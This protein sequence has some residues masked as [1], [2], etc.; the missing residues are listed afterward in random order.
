MKLTCETVITVYTTGTCLEIYNKAV[1]ISCRGVTTGDVEWSI[2]KR[3]LGR[4]PIHG[5]SAVATIVLHTFWSD[6]RSGC[7]LAIK[8]STCTLSTCTLT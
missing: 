3:G 8:L 4:R 2:L 6:V 7:Q 1:E 5:W